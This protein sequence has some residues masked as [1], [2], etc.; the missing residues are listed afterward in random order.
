MRLYIVDRSASKVVTPNGGGKTYTQPGMFVVLCETDKIKD[1]R[2]VYEVRAFVKEEE[3]VAF[4]LIPG[5][6]RVNFAIVGKE[7]RNKDASLD[8]FR[9][10]GFRITPITVLTEL[11]DSEGK[12]IGYRYASNNGTVFMR[13]TEDFLKDCAE[14]V[15]KAW[16]SRTQLAQEPFKPVQ[17]MKYIPAGAK[18]NNTGKA[19]VS[20]YSES[21]PLPV[22]VIATSRN[23][24]ASA[25]EPKVQKNEQNVSK[26]EQLESIFTKEQLAELRQADKSKVDIRII[27]NPEL[28]PEQ[29]HSI[30]TVEA[31]GF[32]ARKYA[33]PEYSVEFMNFLGLMLQTGTDISP[34]LVPK[35]NKDQA[36]EILA[37]RTEGLDFNEYA[38]PSNSADIMRSIRKDMYHNIWGANIIAG[39]GIQGR[40]VSKQ[41]NRN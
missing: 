41:L 29:M 39:G 18:S 32:P 1:N 22:E 2:R 11:H 15:D 21:N 38:D 8:R 35:Y 13:R 7:I 3:L 33:T 25:E 28:S 30:W 6:E 23:Q 5:M 12:L 27:G 34:V 17:N 16:A 26:K 36:L 20:I 24:Y 40:R 14:L 31:K 4:A 10:K 37:G 19:F 9:Q